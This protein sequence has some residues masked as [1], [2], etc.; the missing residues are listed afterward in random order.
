MFTNPFSEQ[1][2]DLFNLVTKEV[3]PEKIKEVLCNQNQIGQKLFEAFVCDCIQSN[4]IN[5]WSTM[6]K[7]QLGTWKDM[8][9]KMKLSAGDK[10]VELQENRSLFAR[11]MVM[12]NSRAEINLKEAIGQYEFSVVPRSLFAVDGAMHHCSMKSSLIDDHS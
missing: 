3:V 5:L 12:L 6:K 9:K 8:D 11:M 1:S 4:K 7:H 2:N 10:V